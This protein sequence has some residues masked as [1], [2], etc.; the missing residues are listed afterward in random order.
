MTAVDSIIH[1]A[2]EMISIFTLRRDNML[3]EMNSQKWTKV[4]GK[5][6]ITDA[7]QSVT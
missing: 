6:L 4:K 5:L 7:L 1:A 3:P 2:S